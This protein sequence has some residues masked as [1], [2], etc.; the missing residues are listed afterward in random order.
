MQEGCQGLQGILSA[1]GKFIFRR[2]EQDKNRRR[3]EHGGRWE[4]KEAGASPCRYSTSS[5]NPEAN[6]FLFVYLGNGVIGE[7]RLLGTWFLFWLGLIR[8]LLLL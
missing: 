8:V 7:E 6:G 1:L 4:S 5:A 3:G 2:L